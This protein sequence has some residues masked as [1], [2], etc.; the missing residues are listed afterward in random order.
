MKH[1][2]KTSQNTSKTTNRSKKEKWLLAAMILSMC[3]WG[4]SWSCAKVLG[5][6]T[7][8]LNLSFMRFVLV[9]LTLFPLTYFTKI[10]TS[11]SRKGWLYVIGASVFILLYTLLFFE[12]VHQGFAGAGGVLVT[13]INPIFA[14]IIGLFISKILPKKQ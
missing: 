5:N 11:V 9:P 7:S 2:L 8:S 3:V 1:P 10:K 14:Y 4:T 6:Y 13:T 12:G